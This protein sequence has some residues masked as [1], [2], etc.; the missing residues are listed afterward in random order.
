MSKATGFLLA[1]STFAVAVITG[2]DDPISPIEV[3]RLD[4]EARASTNAPTATVGAN[5]AIQLVW[6]DNATNESGWEVHRS[7][8]GA[9]GAFTLLASLTST[10]YMDIGLAAATEYCYKVRSYRNSGKRT[11]YAAFSDV[12]CATTFPRP[13][14]PFELRGTPKDFGE[15]E[16][17]WKASSDATAF[18]I[19]RSGSAQDAWQ[20]VG[21][22]LGNTTTFREYR[23]WEVLSC[24]RVIAWNK[25]NVQSEPS[26]V[27]CTATPQ[28]PVELSATAGSS[29]IKLAWTDN[30]SIED[31]YEVWRSNGTESSLVA[32][33][34]TNAVA[35]ED[36][37]IVTD[38]VYT[39]QV[40]ATRDGGF[41]QFSP[42]ASAG[43]ATNA[44]PAPQGI[45]ATPAGSS[46][47]GVSWITTL[48]ATG[49][50]IQRSL[51]AGA[52]WVDAGV[53]DD[54][55]WVFYDGVPSEETIHY[56]VIAFNAYGESAPSQ[57][58][59]TAAP[60]APTAGTVTSDGAGNYNVTW[61]DNSNVEEGYE[62]WVVTMA[63]YFPVVLTGPN[64][65]SAGVSFYNVIYAT[66][67]AVRDGG[68]SDFSDGMP[69]PGYSITKPSIDLRKRVM[70]TGRKKLT[71]RP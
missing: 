39:Y 10:L 1:A 38:V 48:L 34:P 70:A 45:S 12:T 20:L 62:V 49:Y 25:W 65:T 52:T 57:P 23:P 15:I 63:D 35:Y 37:A 71:T 2:C 66:V 3:S 6:Q 42:S 47:I 58:D 41:S 50:R 4:A 33:L 60:N 19:Y 44:P 31:G 61:L 32:K 13:A 51:D 29:S 68:Y 40:R 21:N 30:S 53:V 67:A 24:Y 55:T 17:T 9:A 69:A 11:S 43:I 64:A 7:T 46:V 18:D 28:S 5:F 59:F 8:T 14:A 22:V 36:A 54:T 16:L 26:N 56:R 27:I